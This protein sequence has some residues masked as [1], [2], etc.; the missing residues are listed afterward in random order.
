MSFIFLNAMCIII[1]QILGI[2]D[3]HGLGWVEFEL[4]LSMIL[5]YFMSA[6]ARLEIWA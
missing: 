6:Q 1:A 3:A 4:G 2:R 5:T